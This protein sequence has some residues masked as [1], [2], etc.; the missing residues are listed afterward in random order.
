[1]RFVQVRYKLFEEAVITKNVF[2]VVFPGILSSGFMG[3]PKSA[4]RASKWTSRSTMAVEGVI[5]QLL[6]KLF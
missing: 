3:L 6:Q 5:Q 2:F 4:D 1:M